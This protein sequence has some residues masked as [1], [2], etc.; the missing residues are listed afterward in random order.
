MTQSS[1]E[2]IPREGLS[3]EEFIKDAGRAGAI[4]LGS[5]AVMGALDACGGSST[6]TTTKAGT[7]SSVPKTETLTMASPDDLVSLDPAFSSSGMD[8]FVQQAVFEGLQNY[9]PNGGNAVQ[10]RLAESFEVSSDG[11]R[12]HFRL[13]PG[14]MFHKG[15]G[16]VTGADVKFSFERIAGLTKPNLNSPYATDWAALDRVELN[17]PYEGTVI[18]K[19]PYAPLRTTVAYLSGL[20]VSQKA[21]EKLGKAFARNPVGTGPYE[22]TSWTP[23]QQLTL[24]RFTGWHGSPAPTRAHRVQADYGRAD[25]GDWAR[26]RGAGRRSTRVPHDPAIAGPQWDNRP[27]AADS[28]LRVDRDEHAA[29][30]PK[31]HQRSSGDPIRV[32]CTRDADCGLRGQG[33]TRECDPLTGHAGGVLGRC[34]RL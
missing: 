33:P 30:E 26:D 24:T 1:D 19:S 21:V 25:K 16:E 7:P 11:L 9:A 23:N 29:P 22:F 10:D 5:G 27:L 28:K 17:G 2:D 32:G 31:R 3:R 13:K 12:V 34:A 18:L 6:S 14:V 8:N 4:L 20:V 15:Y